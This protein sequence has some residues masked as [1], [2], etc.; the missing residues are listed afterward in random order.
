MMLTRGMVALNLN[1]GTEKVENDVQ[2]LEMFCS[3]FCNL[4][5]A[6]SELALLK[7]L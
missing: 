1:V 5:V 2:F 4:G 3:I 6:L 7:R